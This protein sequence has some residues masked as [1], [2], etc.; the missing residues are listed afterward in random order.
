MAAVVIIHTAAQYWASTPVASFDWNVLNLYDG[1]ARW[2]VPV[3]VM[4]S[5]SLLLDPARQ[6]T[7]GKLWRKNVIRIL[8][9]LLVWGLLYAFVY[10]FP[11]EITLSSVLSFCKAWVGGHY[12]MWFLF[13]IA[14]L[15]IV[16]PFLRCVV[17]DRK[18]L[19]Y[20]L[21]LSFFISVAVPFVCEAGGVMRV[22]DMLESTQLRSL[23]G[24][25][26]YYVL[27]Y[28]LNTTSLSAKAREA[29]VLLGA[30]G[31]VLT[32][33]LTALVSIGGGKP[34][35]TFY[36]NFSLPVCMAASGVFVLGSKASVAKERKR[37]VVKS[38]SDASL[39]V[40]LVH[41]LVLDALY[42]MGIDSMMF[43]PVLAVPLTA[44][45]AMALSF[46]ISM[47][48]RKVP[49]AGKWLV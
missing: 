34:L 28:W 11:K 45:V 10:H 47:A 32:V 5:G 44:G 13:M 22:Y 49:V 3:F 9:V 17:I 8:V 42:Q 16:T 35:Q 33:A 6:E 27:G 14:G 46:A 41:I 23:A 24:Y 19:R 20:F 26:F 18:V 30:V 25:P 40:Y 48:I 1:L 43:T 2:A 29:I 36:G 21:L 38:L 7:I 39:G 37:K 15:Y 31:L 12:H 4:I